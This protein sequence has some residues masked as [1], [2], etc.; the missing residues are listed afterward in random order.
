[1]I[2]MCPND[3]KFNETL[4]RCVPRMDK[5]QQTIR[6]Y[7]ESENCGIMIPDCN[8]DGKF[9]VPSN[10]SYYYDCQRNS[11]NYF[12][13]VYRCPWATMYHPDLHRCIPMANCYVDH[14]DMF[15]RFDY[16]LFPKCVLRGQF[17]TSRNCNLYYRCIPNMDGSFFQIRYECPPMMYYNVDLERCQTKYFTHCNYIP[18]HT[19]VKEYALKHDLSCDTYEPQHT[20]SIST[21][22]TTISTSV[23]STEASTSETN[24]TEPNATILTTTLNTETS[25]P[26]ETDSQL[27]SSTMTN[28]IS[29]TPY[30]ETESDTTDSISVE[31]TETGGTEDT[32]PTKTT[33]GYRSTDST[34]SVTEIT[35]SET[36]STTEEEEDY[37]DF[38]WDDGAWDPLSKPDDLLDLPGYYIRYQKQLVDG[39]MS[40]ERLNADV[41][42]RLRYPNAYR[43]VAYPKKRK[44]DT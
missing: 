29:T 2:G 18:W 9:P 34:D 5:L 26:Q 38:T 30:G 1:M 23:S 8:K 36:Q 44:A 7:D 14:Y 19:I 33:E 13:Y 3:M 10:C 17:R 31:T 11:H 12:Q 40:D 43:I 35:N 20:T 37:I 41:S 16:E 22:N 6:I 39:A 28:D 24:I 27:T 25:E 21:L 32:E 42:L 15:D 4:G